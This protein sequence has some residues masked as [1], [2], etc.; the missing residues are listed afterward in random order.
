VK[1][2]T[3]GLWAALVTLSMIG[4]TGCAENEAE[5]DKLAKTIGSP[6]EMNPKA[7][8]TET[9][10]APKTQAEFKEHAEAIQSKMYTKGST[11]PGAKKK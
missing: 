8:P 10:P 5:A 4:V 1:M 11:Y 7:I 2:F 9:Q 3:C 6:G